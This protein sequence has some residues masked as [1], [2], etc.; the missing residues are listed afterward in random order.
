MCTCLTT[1]VLLTT[2]LR[3]R[4][5]SLVLEVPAFDGE[6]VKWPQKPLGSRAGRL[7]RLCVPLWVQS[8]DGELGMLPLSSFCSLHLL[9]LAS[10]QHTE[11]QIV[12]Q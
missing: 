11:L 12:R 2:S 7:P 8:P 3:N 10:Q 6:T 9:E 1:P 5:Y 4:S